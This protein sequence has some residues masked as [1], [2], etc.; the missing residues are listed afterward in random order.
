MS[1]VEIMQGNLFDSECDILVNPVNCVGVMGAGLAKTFKE[2][3]AHTD[4]F[5][6]YK[7]FCN[8]K[9]FFYTGALPRYWNST[10]PDLHGVMFFP[11]KK[12]WKDNSE[13][14]KIELSLIALRDFKVFYNESIAFPLLGCGLG[15]LNKDDVLPLMIKHLEKSCFKKVEIYV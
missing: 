14:D 5:D 9:K 11:T 1:K 2:R 15:G 6:V 4:M 7:F 10:D 3:Y 8:S 13:I 12:H